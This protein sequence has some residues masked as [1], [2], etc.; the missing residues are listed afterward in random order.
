MKETKET[1]ETNEC[2]GITGDGSP[3][4]RYSSDVMVG[5]YRCEVWEIH[6]VD[7]PQVLIYGGDVVLPLIYIILAHFSVPL[8][9]DMPV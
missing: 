3:R 6:D 9:V 2:V 8:N 7:G 5:T 4:R 1:K